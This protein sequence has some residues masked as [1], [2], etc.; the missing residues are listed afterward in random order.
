M[1][2][3]SKGK[4]SRSLSFQI[5]LLYSFLAAVNITFFSVMI[6]ENQAELIKDKFILESNMLAS[7]LATE[8]ETEISSKNYVVDN[9]TIKTIVESNAGNIKYISIVEAPPVNTDPLKK[10]NKKT[11]SQ[12][13]KPEELKVLYTYD[14]T[15]EKKNYINQDFLKKSKQLQNDSINTSK[16]IKEADTEDMKIR[17]LFPFK[18]Q[19]DFEVKLLFNVQEK[20]RVDVKNGKNIFIYTFIDLK[21]IDELRYKLWL[22][23]ITALIW[24]IVFHTLFAIYVYRVIFIRV[25][26]L[27]QSSDK[28]GEGDLHTRAKWKFSRGDE[29]DDL[30][31][32]FNFMAEKIESN[33]KEIQDKAR[34]IEEDS[35]VITRLNAEIN[36]ELEIGKEVQEL[37]L[38]KKVKYKAFKLA[39]SYR[40]MR[41]VSGD[42]Y[43]FFK[44]PKH[45]NSPRSYSAFFFAD[46]SGH[47]VSAALVTVV[48]VMSID[49]IVK[50][51]FHPGYVIRKLSEMM[52]NRLQASFFATA[53]FFLINDKGDVYVS[54]AG[55][56]APIVYRPSTG[57]MRFIKS[58]GPPLGMSEDHPYKT[59]RIKTQAGDKIFIY[60]DG[61]TESPNETEEQFS[62]ERVIELIKTNID[63]PNNE[64]LEILAEK[65][66]EFKIEYRDDVSMLLLEI[67]E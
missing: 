54:N 7:K 61:L 26:I 48:M 47:G 38:S 5:G 29:L 46:A 44:F 1:N 30:G 42:I 17:L 64:V 45:K 63:K 2:K 6:F 28:M 23:I 40:P 56:N 65:L 24:G 25:G 49:A 16:Y 11:E 8:I 35:K 13:G 55:H 66:D 43:H 37:F 51:S 33:V 50:E 53:V 36:Q 21:S 52:S 62:E 34:K 58:S 19:G 4:I 57:D 9:D 32:S 22:Q 3:P 10:D 59:E 20:E 18:G 39:I 60:S 12:E 31:Q 41:E 67:P 15:E 14:K 27:K